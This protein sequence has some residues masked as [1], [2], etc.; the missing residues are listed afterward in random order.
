MTKPIPTTRGVLI[1]TSKTQAKYSRR[2]IL[3]RL[4]I[5][6]GFLPLLSTERAR[7]AAPSGYPTR[8]IA[9]T[10]TD[11]ICP[12]NFYPTGA[13]G[14]LPTTLPSTFT[15]L[16]PWSSKLL[17]LRHATK[18]QSPID[19]NVMMDVGSRYGGHFT[20][21]AMLT[22]GVSSPN[23]TDEVPTIMA[24]FPSIDQIYADN[25][26][27]QGVSNAQLNVGC[28][29][30]KSYTSFRTGGTPNTQQNDPYKLFT[31]LFGGAGMTPVDMNALIARRKSVLDYVGGELTGFAKNLGTADKNNV[32]VHLQSVKSLEDQLKPSTGA[33]ATCSSPDIT[34][35]GLNFNT[36]ANYPKHV[37]FMSDIVAAAVV[38]GK[39]R[40]VT[41][42]LIDN[43]GGNSLTFPWLNIPSPDF[44]A[45]AHQGS[46]NYAQK[47][48]ID[49][50]F[51][52]ACV[53]E[54]VSKLAAVTE[55][56]GTVLDNTVILV[57]NDMSEGAAHYVGQI[58]YVII[59]SGG[60]FFK[61][62]RM[63]TFPNQVP[64]NQL[65]TSVLHALGMTSVTGVGDPKY[66]GSLDTALTT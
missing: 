34:P 13:A 38:C 21:P 49:Q 9:I 19:I 5:G 44:H 3:K 26:L 61:T 23:G 42:D 32:M 41:M 14:A 12:P 22:G 11:G 55:G 16:Q 1:Q 40:A 18:Q 4:G 52:T 58:P 25:L 54:V 60:G 2:A 27:T 66:T 48:V 33:P 36:I 8:F 30:Y 63:V 20:Y 28:R 6:A 45:I 35:T 39:S 31:S 64:N 53:A 59:G 24:T 46:A 47:A 7:A 15:G 50:W 10:W 37:Q 62:G 29:P 57:G 51:Y 56:N 43:G 17:L 65:L